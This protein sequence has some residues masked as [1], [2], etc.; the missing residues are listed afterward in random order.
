MCCGGHLPGVPE[1]VSGVERCQAL[2]FSA[3]P[4][5]AVQRDVSVPGTPYRIKTYILVICLATL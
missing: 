1:V 5:A 2:V 3:V 4:T